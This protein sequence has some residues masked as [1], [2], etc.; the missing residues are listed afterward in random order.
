MR[1]SVGVMDLK[2]LLALVLKEKGFE[3]LWNEDGCA[4]EISDLM[5]C[6]EPSPECQAGKKALCDGTCEDG[7]CDFHIVPKV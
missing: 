4:C 2:E 5:P 3:G 6:G 7:K 1:G